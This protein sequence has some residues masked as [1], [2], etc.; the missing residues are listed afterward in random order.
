MP[1][2]TEVALECLKVAG[3][4][5]LLMLL[6]AVRPD[7]ACP[8]CGTFSDRV[9][10]RYQRKL[11]DLPWEG[12]PVRVQ[13]R[14][15]RFFCVRPECSQTIFAERF[16]STVMRYGRRTCRLSRAYS[17]LAMAL[18]GQA[19]ARLAIEL[20]IKT[21]GDSLL[22]QLRR[23]ARSLATT[24]PRVL[25]VDDWAWRKGR[26]YGTILCDLERGKVV[27]LLPDRSAESTEQWLR[28]HPG[29]EIIS[30]DRASLYAEAA[31]R[32]APHAVQVADRWHL[33]HNMSEALVSALV[34]HHRLLAELAQALARGS[35]AATALGVQQSPSTQPQPS[36]PLANIVCR[37]RTESVAWLATK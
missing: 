29:A 23:S 16:P 22:R 15:R 34:P 10:S 5:Q 3:P 7:S 26:R 37:S 33:L 17:V 11:S 19:G 4:G 18:G 14:T 9:H 6:R 25:G 24:S 30:R 31:T 36:H 1:D 2:A 27:D 8:G 32:A 13:L 28:T 20:G 35:K 12:L 21:S